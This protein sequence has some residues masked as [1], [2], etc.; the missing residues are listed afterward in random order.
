[1]TRRVVALLGAL[2]LVVG[3]ARP[4]KADD[5]AV[6]ETRHENT[7][8]PQNFALE[9]RAALYNP[10]VDSDPQLKDL[11]SGKKPFA[12]SFGSPTRFEVGLEFD[13]QALRIP[14][15][16][17]LGPGI[18]VGYY[19]V[20]ALAPLTDSPQ[21]LSGETTTLEI[22]PM[23]AVA[24]FRLDVLWRQAHIPLVPYAKAGVGLA[25]WRASN[26][27]GTSVSPPPGLVVGEGH[28]WGSQFAAGLAFNIG[29]LD[30]NSVRQLDEATGI[31]NTYLFAEF[32]AA[33]LD[34]IAQSDPLRVGSDSFAF[35]VSFEF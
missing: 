4:A 28:T 10:Q 5:G 15:V 20:S 14:N 21:T 34:G 9:I 12:A 7:L 22:L 1:V 24:V 35:G 8:S 32:M 18:S 13:W 33:T 16:G 27:V 17:S 3:I 23:Y 2:G 11:S 6:L 29:V 25:L 31:N 19:N 26:T 30:P